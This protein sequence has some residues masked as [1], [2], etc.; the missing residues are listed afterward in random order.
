M[1]F[2][3]SSKAEAKDSAA[4]ESRPGALS[5]ASNDSKLQSL[6]PAD[7]DEDAHDAREAAREAAAAK[8]RAEKLD[9]RKQM[10]RVVLAKTVQKTN[11]PAAWIG[12]ELNAM[13]T[14]EGEE[15]IEVRL[16]VQV[17]EPRFLTY[18]SSFQAELERRLLIAAP[19]V[20]HW[21]SGITWKIT[22]DAIY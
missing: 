20:R 17:D 14:P 8:A 18:I 12:G 15:W 22:P 2:F 10:L 6:P 4:P 19:D 11:V 3:R 16:S 9:V 13:V 21:L 1:K 7:D 5:R